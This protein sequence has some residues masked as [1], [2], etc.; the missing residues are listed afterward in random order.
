[1]EQFLWQLHLAMVGPQVTGQP[2][3]ASVTE[4]P[5][6]RIVHENINKE[7]KTVKT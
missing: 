2:P 6:V 7:I 5:R 1:M 4:A 3:T